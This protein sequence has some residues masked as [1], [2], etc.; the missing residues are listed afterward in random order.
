MA[1]NKVVNK[2]TKSHGA[3]R[4]VIEYVLRD[5]KVREGHVMILGPY[6]PDVINYDEIYK[7]W[8]EEKKLWNKDNGRMYAH[9]I[10]SFHESEPI[11]PEQVLDIGRQFAEEFFPDHQSVIA[12]HQDKNHLHCHIVTNSVSY[13]DGSKLHQTRKDLEKQKDF[14]N[15]LCLQLGHTI[16]QKGKHFDGTPIEEWDVTTWSKDKYNLLRNDKKTGYVEKCGRAIMETLPQS[17]SREEFIDNMKQKGWTVHWHDKRKHIVFENENGNKVRDTNIE[18]TF[19]KDVSK[20]ALLHEF[21]RQSAARAALLCSGRDFDYDRDKE[22]EH[23]KWKQQLDE[24]YDQ[25]RS[26]IGGNDP[27][28][29]TIESD[30]STDSRKESAHCGRQGS[31][32]E[33]DPRTV[34]A[35]LNTENGKEGKRNTAAGENIGSG[36]KVVQNPRQKQQPENSE[37]GIVKGERRSENSKSGTVKGE[38]RSENSESGIAKGERRSESSKSR[39]VK[40]ERGSENSESGVVNGERRSEENIR[41]TGQ[42]RSE[43]T[44]R[45]VRRRRGR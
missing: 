8:M 37:S 27:A 24:Y 15:D 6:P 43:E 40:G 9:N 18:K 34:R 36:G 41:N 4:N 5:E 22:R 35:D 16:A 44:Q 17:A 45:T 11:T 29:E 30:R 19:N 28:G 25:I 23:E 1:I 32:S 14:T 38:R 12:V 3:M 26:A 21:E 39:V 7:T 31:R 20:E 33:K 13:I 2:S 10:I 42:E